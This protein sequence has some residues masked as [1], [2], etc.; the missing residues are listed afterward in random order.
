MFYISCVKQQRKIILFPRIFFIFL[1]AYLKQVIDCYCLIWLAVN[2]R[3]STCDPSDFSWNS[4][5]KKDL[6]DLWETLPGCQLV[7]SGVKWIALWHENREMVL[8]SHSYSALNKLFR[9]LL[10]E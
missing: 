1:L 2:T 8:F 7:Y 9:L 3:I 6:K 4:P 10:K 5:T